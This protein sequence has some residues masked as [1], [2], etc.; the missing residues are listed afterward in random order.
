MRILQGMRGISLFISM[1]LQSVSY[2][3]REGRMYNVLLDVANIED[4]AIEVS[5][6]D[7]L[8]IFDATLD[9]LN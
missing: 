1:V 5:G 4:I 3:V 7:Y 9:P 8:Y 2:T 6:D